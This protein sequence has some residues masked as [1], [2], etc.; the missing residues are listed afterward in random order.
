MCTRLIERMMGSNRPRLDRV[1]LI[2]SQN[3]SES[4]VTGLGAGRIGVFGA[5]GADADGAGAGGEP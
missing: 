5:G 3:A 1:S 4:S 2:E